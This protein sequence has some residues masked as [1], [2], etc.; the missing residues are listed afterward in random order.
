MTTNNDRWRI[1]IH[2]SGHAVAC[3]ALNGECNGLML[4]MDGGMAFIENL[5]QD[6]HAYMVAAGPLSER[7]ATEYEAP[8][9]E[10]VSLDEVA[11]N[12]PTEGDKTFAQWTTVA[13]ISGI[14]RGSDSDDRSLALWAI[15]GRES[16]P[17]TWARRVEFACMVAGEIVEKNQAAILRIGRSL[18]Q[19]GALTAPEIKQLYEVQN[20]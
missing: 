9:C 4:H 19:R 17:D 14:N 1:A 8:S 11:E 15:G 3:L 20:D 7:L 2:E 18:F 13:N 6:R 12:P 16:E 5:F 10:V